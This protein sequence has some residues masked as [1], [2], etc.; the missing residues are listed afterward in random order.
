[1]LS[2]ILLGFWSA[3]FAIVTLTNVTD[4]LR[5][6]GVLPESWKLASGNFELV[7]RT[8]SIYGWPRAV[9]WAMFAGVIAWELLATLLY[10]RA[11]LSLGR[12]DANRQ[13]D[14]AVG[15]GAGLFSAFILADELFIA[16]PTGI[17]GTHLR[18]FMAQLVTW[19]VVRWQ[20]R[21][22]E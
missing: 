3:W 20:C 6:A 14:A 21:D 11:A 7:V 19:L 2:R 12:A 22:H 9:A 15:L 18:I 10:G 16:F 5:S 4:A 1:M 17:E 8:I 13:I